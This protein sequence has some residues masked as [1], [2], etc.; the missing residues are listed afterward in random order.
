[1]AIVFVPEVPMSIP[2]YTLMRRSFLWW[3]AFAWGVSVALALG[4]TMGCRT[5]DSKPA[6]N[7][8]NRSSVILRVG[9]VSDEALRHAI[10]R[11]RGEW[12]ERG[13]GEFETV[14]LESAS[15]DAIRAA[16]IDACVFPSIDLA[17][18][19]EEGLLRPVRDSVL[20][21]DEVAWDDLAPLVR[22]REAVYGGVVMA[23]PLGSAAPLLLGPPDGAGV[24][25]PDDD[26]GLALAF[27][28]WAAP[29]AAHPSTVATLFD[30]TTMAPRLAEPPFERALDSFA[31]AAGSD[32]PASCWVAWPRR[33]DHLAGEPAALAVG[34]FPAAA[35][36]Y[37]P[38][39]RVWEPLAEGGEGAT[40][41]ASRG[42]LLGVT[43]GTRNAADAFR[44]AGWLAGIDNAASLSIASDGVA[45]C[46]GSMGR[47]RDPW[48][49]TS[50]GV[51][52]PDFAASNLEA[53]RCE[54][55]VLAPRLPEGARYLSAL[56]IAV[57]SRLGGTATT[58]ESLGAAAAAWDAITDK[59]GRERQRTAYLRSVGLA[60]Y[61][62]ATR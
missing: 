22:E 31:D 2:R 40:L 29:H 36:S 59:A 11:L 1:M 56:G 35:E 33:A 51:A 34:Q 25:V 16:K 9:V 49:G 10:D 55:W 57:R 53:L 13:V 58:G 43:A 14:E 19:C 52:P 39:G 28:A 54:R 41:V 7:S 12:A 23:L 15:P 17:L 48:I 42:S 20:N 62:A 18:L 27:L 50:D 8:P 4:T 26:T 6:K 60:P 32:R 61:E 38:L 46:R 37:N 5:G 47:A 21:R 30:A 3:G 24:R 45:V 44:L